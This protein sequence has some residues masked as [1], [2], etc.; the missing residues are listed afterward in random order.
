MSGVKTVRLVLAAAAT[1]AV[2]SGS[3]GAND[4]AAA[5]DGF[6]PISCTGAP[7]EIRLIVSNVRKGV[8]ILKV[9]LYKNDQTT[10]LQGEGRLVQA[11]FAARAPETKVCLHAPGPGRYAIGLYHDKNNSGRFDKGPLGLPAEPFGVSNNPR[12][13]FAAP[14]IEEAL[15]E[16]PDTSVVVTIKLRSL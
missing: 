12:M 6:S 13:Q 2:L 3:A 15:F 5:K 4:S 10:W 16:V 8:G 11:R 14:K 7:N 9:E 1:A